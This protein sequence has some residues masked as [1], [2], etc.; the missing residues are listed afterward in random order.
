MSKAGKAL[1]GG[2]FSQICGKDAI[3]MQK[4]LQTQA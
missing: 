1:P 4:I 3:G 2:T